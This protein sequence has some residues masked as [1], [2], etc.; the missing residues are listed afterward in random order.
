VD[1]PSFILKEMAAEN[2]KGSKDESIFDPLAMA[3]AVEQLCQPQ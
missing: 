1:T 3:E 2:K